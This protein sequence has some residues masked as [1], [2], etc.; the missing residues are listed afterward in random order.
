MQTFVEA[1]YQ[2]ALSNRQ[3]LRGLVEAA[4]SRLDHGMGVAA[5]S[6]VACEGAVVTSEASTVGM[7][8]RVAARLAPIAKAVALGKTAER[9]TQ[10]AHRG[11]TCVVYSTT[12]GEG[13]ETTVGYEWALLLATHPQGCATVLAAPRRSRGSATDRERSQHESMVAH[14]G[15]GLRLRCLPRYR[16]VSDDACR[17]SPAHARLAV[18]QREDTH[19][20]RC[21]AVTADQQVAKNLRSSESIQDAW[22]G[23]VLGQLPQVDVFECEGRRYIIAR[24]DRA[25]GPSVALTARQCRV[26]ALRSLGHPLKYIAV[27]ARCSISTVSAEIARALRLLGLRTVGEL[28]ACTSSS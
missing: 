10:G 19:L 4:R 16:E 22:Q 5:I 23:L 9:S 18:S 6:F 3:W 8:P 2:P 25:A 1:V 24:R 20:L 12:P 7:E 21:S 28:G 11:R 15:C 27:E 14:L 26:L 17:D 13:P